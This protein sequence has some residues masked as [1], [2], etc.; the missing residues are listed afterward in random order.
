MLRDIRF[1]IRQ[2]WKSKGFTTTAVV[3]LAL[4]IGANSA[5]FT[6]I[7]AILLK[8]LP[9]ADPHQLFRLG[10]S[11]NCCVIGGAQTRFSIFSYPLYTYLRG[12]T[13]EFQE[14]AAFQAGLEKVG[15]RRAGA[16][17]SEPFTDQFVS[18]NYFTMFGLRPFAGRLLSPADDARGA[19]PV[20]VMSYRAW[21]QRYAGDLSVIGSTFIIDGAAFTISGIA[22]AG[23]FGDTLRLDPPD[24]WMPLADEP[25]ARRQNSLLDRADQHWLY[26]IGRVKPGA[27]VAAIETEVNLE[28]RQWFLANGWAA[29]GN[30]QRELERQH[31]ALAP[32]GG[33]VA[34]MKQDY[35]HELRL[36]MGITAFVL[37]IAC[38]NL[39]NLQLARAAS[40]L[41]QISIRVA[42]GAR[43]F[44]LIR[45]TLIESLILAVAGGAAGL[46]LGA[47]MAALLM[48]LAFGTRTFIPIETAPSLP[49]MGFTFLAA[50]AAGVIFG[51]APA[52]SASRADPAIALHGAGRSTGHTSLPQKSLV[53]LQA[54]LSLVLVAGAGLMVETLR[55]LQN[56]Q[57]GF[58]VE[59]SMVA[60][61]NAGFSGYS[62]DRLSAIY[63]DIDRRLRQIPGVRE[64]GLALYSPMSG[65]NWQSGVTLQEHPG[66][67]VSPAWDRVSP[68]FFP[69]VGFRVLHGRIFDDRDSPYTTRAAVVNQA[70]ADRYF[71]NEDPLGKRFGLGGVEYSADYEIIG[72][73][74]N[75]LFR[76]PR[77]PDPH[78][79]FFLPLRQF[80]KGA[81]RSNIIHNIVLRT[82][83][84]PPDLT[85]QI[86][87]A[88][89]AADLNLTLVD[90]VPMAQQ[91]SDLL[92]QERL[93]ARL[94][95]CFGLLALLLASVGLYGVT[96][97]AVSRRTREIGVRT[98]LGATPARI[99]GMVLSGAMTQIGIGLAIGIPGALAA[100]RVLGDQLYGVKTS[101]PMVLSAAAAA[102]LACAVLAGFIAALRAAGID[103]VRALRAER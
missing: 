80:P 16:P 10:D 28:L 84:A 25:P 101:D 23:F 53:V 100:G 17:A 8:S 37:L 38:A 93:I 55:N 30:G 24:F 15:V 102:I 4:G 62:A 91:L 70:F 75:V 1:A 39:A 5:I 57:F 47:E 21:Q 103:P 18:G 64:V 66:Q 71:P 99:V 79:M 43:R 95:A 54:A 33:G 86:Q 82:A 40:N 51:V 46:F 42:I 12:H 31:I 94:A 74:S 45:Q 92:T 49:V 68:G 32:A 2:L 81:G 72:V 56:Q 14:M 34:Q 44:H 73:V 61:V 9:V 58:R 78:P 88:F 76:N 85:A 6:L 35:E 97:Y 50:L 87:R 20:A 90:V 96:A 65:N 77:H 67:M 83:G 63:G 27:H 36:L 48:R 11:E 26:I 41:A 22:P 98:A 3:T 7:H 89:A 69:A 13:P 52:W 19:P 59:G 29:S 60:N